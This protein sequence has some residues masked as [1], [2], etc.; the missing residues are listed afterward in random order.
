MSA[1]AS[2]SRVPVG[3]LLRYGIVGASNTAVT[4]AVYTA[5]VAVGTPAAAA[6]A[7]GWVLGAVNG[8]R[9]N[10]GWTFRS[11]VRGPVPAARY[12]TVQA[13]AAGADA[14]GVALVVGHDHLPRLAGQVAVLPVVTVATFLICRRWVFAPEHA[15]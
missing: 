14:L 11:A 9:I 10:R 12:A 3:Q 2:T 13:V 7:A 5:L 15:A 6:A 4:L 1:V 8:Y